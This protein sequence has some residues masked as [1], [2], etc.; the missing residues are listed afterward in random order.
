MSQ[1][2]LF[3]GRLFFYAVFLGGILLLAY[4]CMRL[5]RIFVR[6][7]QWAMAAEEI[8]FWIAAAA[9]IYSMIY[10]CNSGAVRNY[11]V[12]GMGLGMLL[13]RSFLSSF[14]IRGMLWILRP[15]R[16]T[17]QIFKTFVK[18]CSKI[19]EICSLKA[20]NKSQKA[21]IQKTGGS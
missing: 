20:Y 2:V 8:V 12:C 13:Y 3:Q 17:F 18:E 7:R 9:A 10:H 11:I 15:V 4:D 5:L 6:H 1:D 14:F 19:I 16:K 21:T